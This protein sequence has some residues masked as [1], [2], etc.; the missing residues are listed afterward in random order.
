M[1]KVGIPMKRIFCI[2]IAVLLLAGCSDSN[3]E[4]E[5]AMQIRAEMIAK[6]VEFDTDIT[7]DYGNVSYSFS[8]HCKV[9]TTGNMT[10]E[11]TKPESLAGI[12]GSVS[13]TG[14]KLTFDDTALAFELMADGQLTPVSSPWVLVKTMR[15]GYLSSCCMEEEL[16]RATID[17]S[18]KEDALHLDIWFGSDDAPVQAEIYWQGRRLL[19][20]RIENFTMA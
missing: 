11:V 1:D 14:G 9:D 20:M 19:S 18:Y 10:F 4:L 15:S 13:T 3:A 8:M 5:R 17:D 7:A 16:L 2:L 6:A 12:S